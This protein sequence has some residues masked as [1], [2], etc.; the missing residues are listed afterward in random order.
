MTKDPGVWTA[1][2][3]A[4]VLIDYHKEMFGVIRSA[5]R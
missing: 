1:E 3:S 2:D 5:W 4:L